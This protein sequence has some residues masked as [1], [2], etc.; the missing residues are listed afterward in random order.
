MKLKK[1]NKENIDHAPIQSINE[2]NKKI[3]RTCLKKIPV[4]SYMR[5]TGNLKPGKEKAYLIA[6]VR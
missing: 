5:A 3:E 4:P 1:K 2:Y 6:T